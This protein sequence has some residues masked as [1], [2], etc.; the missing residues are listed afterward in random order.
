MV[1]KEK[2]HIAII[3]TDIEIAMCLMINGNGHLLRHSFYFHSKSI[4]IMMTFVGVCTTQTCFLAFGGQTVYFIIM[5]FCPTFY[6]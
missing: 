4:K 1:K 6:L 5:T 3:M 2:K